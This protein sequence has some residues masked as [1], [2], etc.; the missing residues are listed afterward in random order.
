MD[1]PKKN[2]H[3]FPLTRPWKEN[4]A[5]RLKDFAKR[6]K[7]LRG[8]NS[9]EE[10]SAKLAIPQTTLSRY[11]QGLNYPSE[12][13][14]IRMAMVGN[15]TLDW[16]LLGQGM[17]P[18]SDDQVGDSIKRF[19]KVPRQRYSA[20]GLEII[21]KALAEA[22]LSNIEFREHIE[23]AIKSLCQE[24]AGLILEYM[25]TFCPRDGDRP[26]HFG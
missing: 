21:A 20:V 26:P 15:V 1:E 13:V 16:L 12:E 7:D 22:W 18:A 4:K 9:Q 24:R 5:E 17:R 2:Q 25:K 14:L 6:V 10:F 23:Q 19:E 3:S 11:E 8:K